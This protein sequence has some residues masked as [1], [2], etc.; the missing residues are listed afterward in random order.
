MNF[1]VKPGECF[2]LL[3]VNGAGKTTTFK[4]LTGDLQPTS[5]DAFIRGKSIRTELRQV[6]EA[7]GYAPQFD[8]LIDEMS[9]RETLRMYARLKGVPENCIDAI[10]RDL[11]EILLFTPHLDKWTVNLSGG[12][13]RKLTTACS[14]VG[15][16]EIVLL[17]EPSTG[18]DPVAKRHLWNA[19]S[20]FRDNGISIV[21]TTHSLE[22]AEALCTRMGIMVNGRFRCLGSPQHLKNK[23]S[24]GYTLIAQTKIKMMEEPDQPFTRQMSERGRRRSSARQNGS[25]RGSLKRTPLYW[26]TGLE[27]LRAFI[28][29]SF[30]DCVLKDIHP[31]FVHYHV[32]PSENVSWGKMFGAMEEARAKFDLEAYSVGQTSLEQ[33]F[34]NF[35]KAQINE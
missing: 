8:G 2:G 16:P 26:E 31:G 20:L 29:Q 35:S 22:E 1:A 10:I 6:H 27:D 14:M 7:I 30:P 18:M 11:G 13:K 32:S 19:V 24:K 9:A 25:L 17:D 33:V 21:L 28:E 23:F 3:G 34:L 15:K 5:G 4:Q 12:N